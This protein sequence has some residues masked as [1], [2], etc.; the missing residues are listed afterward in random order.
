MGSLK[1]DYFVR[2]PFLGLFT[3]H[4]PLNLDR[5]SLSEKESAFF[6][7]LYHISQQM[8]VV[9]WIKNCRH[10]RISN[11]FRWK[12]AVIMS[13]TLPF[14]PTHSKSVSGNAYNDYHYNNF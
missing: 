11:Q 2:I 5:K 3:L 13:P 9:I 4:Y 12:Y 6:K 8:K 1:T 10:R 14:L 7:L